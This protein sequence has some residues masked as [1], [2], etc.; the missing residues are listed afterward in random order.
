[1]N[2]GLMDEEK[3]FLREAFATIS[4]EMY[5]HLSFI[6]FY[7]LVKGMMKTNSSQNFFS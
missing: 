2:P 6:T 4:A 1:M 3:N 5:G 7:Q